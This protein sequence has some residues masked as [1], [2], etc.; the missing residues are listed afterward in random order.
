MLSRTS[1]PKLANRA[2]L[3]WDKV[4]RRFMLLYPERG[5]VLND[6]ASSILKLCDGERTVG[7]IVEALKS[8]YEGAS[9]AHVEEQVLRFLDA[10][11]ERGLFERGRAG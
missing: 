1:R 3:R 11:V 7:E 4:G 6:T 10:M 5:L 2:R 8:Q 9:P